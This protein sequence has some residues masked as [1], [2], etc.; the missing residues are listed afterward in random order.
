MPQSKRHC[1]TALVWAVAVLPF[2]ALFCALGVDY[3]RAQLAKTE[4]ERTSQAAARYALTGLVD[5]THLA[6]A[7]WIGQHNPA[8]G[9]AVAF[10]AADVEP[11]VWNATTKTFT[12]GGGAPTAV[13]TT[14]RRIVPMVF[15][16]WG[17]K[18][19]FTVTSR[20]VVRFNVLG[21][22]LVGLDAVTMSGSTTA[23][24][25]ANGETGALNQG[26][27]AS[28]GNIT[29]GNATTVYGNTEVG[30]GMSV[31]GGNVIG[32]KSTLSQ[33]LSFPNGS[34]SPYGP[35]NNNN[36]LIPSW[37]YSSGTQQFDLGANQALSLPGGNYYFSTFN[38]EAGATLTLTGPVTIYCYNSLKMNGNTTTNLNRPSNLKIVM[39]PNPNNGNPPGTVTIGSTSSL[40]ANI[41][42]P[43][44]D[45]SI[46]GNGSIYGSVLGKTI[47]MSGN[48]S[49][50]YDMS[51]NAE[52]GTL[53]M[54][55]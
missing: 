4:L 33:P 3:A 51:L 5:G 46:S 10:A 52:N 20:C 35:S 6:K 18:S 12:P 15:G 28:N 54:V 29:L 34:A 26:N 22:G 1:G 48:G 42:A 30:V 40:Y 8:D 43:Q 25:W 36:S 7:N 24:Y 31:I 17:G 16:G 45:V 21:Y 9:K 47:N 27:I 49:V 37:A 11:G 50:Y 38:M 55:E 44:S 14:A 32:T 2:F 19:S 13:R 53:S 23:S 41:Y 39:V